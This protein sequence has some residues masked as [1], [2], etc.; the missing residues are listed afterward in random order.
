MQQV[1]NN[2][3]N[4]Q[5]PSRVLYYSKKCKYSIELYNLL[6]SNNLIKYVKLVCVDEIDHQ[7]LPKSITSVPSLLMQNVHKP[8]T[9][10]ELFSWVNK[11]IQIIGS[12]NKMMGGPSPQHQQQQHQQQQQQQQFQYH[13]SQMQQPQQYQPQQYQSQQYQSQQQ[14]QQ[15]QQQPP[16]PP[17]PPQDESIQ[18]WQQEF[19]N[20]MSD[21]YSFLND[22]CPGGFC[23]NFQFLSDP[24]QST[25]SQMSRS[26]PS[27]IPIDQNNS[28]NAMNRVIQQ[29]P[30][31]VRFS[32][33]A[34][35]PL[36]TKNS[37]EISSRLEQM[38][39]QREHI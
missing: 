39:L 6:H 10:K 32:T 34:T 26:N 8:L 11:Q 2:M 21:N 7:Y 24:S 25:P 13:P 3:Q 14:Y 9:G 5:L 36:T 18:A 16:Q 35:A 4:H 28:F 19:S 33:P 12:H 29:R 23:R 1:S 38:K 31:A 17:Q 27:E 37:D 22:E 15:P 20:G 30:S